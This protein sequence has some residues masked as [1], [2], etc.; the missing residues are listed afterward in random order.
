VACLTE[1]QCSLFADGE[2]PDGEARVAAAHIEACGACRRMVETL[3]VE[4]QVLVHCLQDTAYLE[5]EL[6]DEALSAP[7]AKTL[8]VARF[9]MF[10]LAM[11]ALLR[12]VTNALS[13]MQLPDSLS[14][15]NPLSTPAQLSL[16]LNTLM[17]GIPAAAAIIDSF[18]QTATSIA[19]TV[20][21]CFAVFM[22][23]RRSVLKNALLSVIA[24]LA[25][26]SPFGYAIEVRR[27]SQPVT[28]PPGET[29][30][31]TLVVAAD[32]VNIDG[33]V[34]GDLI[35]FAREVRIRGTVKGNVISCAQRIEVE[36]TVEGSVI[37][38]GGW[39]E[40]RG[41]VLRNLY[42]FAGS[43]RIGSEGRIGGNATV[44]AGEGNVEGS[45]GK[46]FSAYSA[47]AVGWGPFQ[48][49]G[50]GG[51]F[52]IMAP[53]RIG[54][55]LNLKVDRPGNAR[56]DSGA[57]I[58]GRTS[59]NIPP[60]RPSRYRTASFYIWQ[61]IW[62][63]AAF[64]TG[65]VLFWLAPFF[66]GANLETSRSL[67]IA[68]GVGFLAVVATPIAAIIAAVTLVGLPLGLITLAVW[69]IA[70]YLAKIVL[71]GFLGRS[72][73]ASQGNPHPPAPL[74]LLV[75]LLPLFVAINLPYI[76][77][78]IEF[79]FV[80]LGLGMLVTTAYRTVKWQPAQAA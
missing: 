70:G 57:T 61:T 64:L 20:I 62:L 41:Q 66:A 13:E 56:V 71:A 80:V 17:Y 11:S 42:A 48:T 14:W 74:M 45:V 68:G 72:L 3:R 50:Q 15:L 10:V 35:A 47:R 53:A 29:V 27:G 16:L 19:F 73:L 46:D 8:S 54:R 43:V 30:D 4:S 39:V 24:L 33:I 67:L 52:A 63:A 22:L 55:N 34:N 69:I 38:A 26:F 37:S 49:S 6:E 59:I 78:L 77:T 36:G 31:D 58:G 9:G 75:G 40:T 12:P 25:V 51:Q 7:Q 76:G 79:L 1:F 44:F 32:S 21:L 5:F 23:L 18:I 60:P 28:V 2:L 65:L